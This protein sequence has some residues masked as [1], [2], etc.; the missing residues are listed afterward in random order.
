MTLTIAFQ[1][2]LILSFIVLST[3]FEASL[4]KSL[5]KKQC[6]VSFFE[7]NDKS[8][9]IRNSAPHFPMSIHAGESVLDKEE[10]IKL[11]AVSLDS[12]PPPPCANSNK[13]DDSWRYIRQ[14]VPIWVQNT[15]RD[16]GF[17]RFGCDTLTVLA[18]PSILSI[19]RDALPNFLALTGFPIWLR[20]H[21]QSVFKL[22][23]EHDK[24]SLVC[25]NSFESIQ[26]GDHSMQV[27]H[28]MRPLLADNA[29]FKHRRRNQ[30]IVFIHG[31]A[32]G[33]GR[34]WMYR[35]VARP[36]L[37]L[38]YSVAVIGYRTYPDVDALG[39]VEDVKLATTKILQ[40]LP[41]FAE[42][43]VTIIGH[44]SGSH[45]GLLSILDAD[46]L[47]RVPIGAFVGLSGVYDVAKHFE[48][49]TGRGIEE[50]SPLKGACGGSEDAF[51]KYSAENRVKEFI[52]SHGSTML[53]S[54]LFLHGVLDNV[55]PYTATLE[56]ILGIH[57][58]IIDQPTEKERFQTLISPNIG[59]GET[60]FELMMGGETRDQVLSWV[61]VQTDLGTK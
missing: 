53:P 60:L 7:G 8:K 13:D 5:F 55:V 20:R 15:W 38:N 32:W 54:M 49:E 30:L 43:N 2:T 40:E 9:E 16:S 27:A 48:Y 22:N 11:E 21:I 24:E 50:V 29:K 4:P 23:Y 59:H 37:Q 26:Y 19:Y 14:N 36:L 42:N 57:K 12:L 10:S 17:V 33:S 35:L 58:A 56:L 3:T 41:E 31:G 51:M 34:P 1:V 45:I 61:T 47:H 52:G 46:F 39:Q 6:V 28:L 44:S 25:E 18:I